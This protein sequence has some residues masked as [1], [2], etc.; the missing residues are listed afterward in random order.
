MISTRLIRVSI[1]LILASLALFSTVYALEKIDRDALFLL[2]EKDS[3]QAIQDYQKEY[4]PLEALEMKLR[5]KL[6][7]L[8]LKRVSSQ[9]PLEE[10]I[11]Y[12]SL[13]TSLSSNTPP[14]EEF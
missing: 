9:Q 5:G 7:S 2:F 8:E 14:L 12:P 10:T 13:E 4:T 11:V 3:A 1:I 6:P